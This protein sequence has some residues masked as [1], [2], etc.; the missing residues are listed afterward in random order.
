MT[1]A[2]RVNLY[3]YFVFERNKYSNNVSSFKGGSGG[4]GSRCPLLPCNRFFCGGTAILNQAGLVDTIETQALRLYRCGTSVS[5][6]PS[7]AD[8]LRYQLKED[9]SL[10]SLKLR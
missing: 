3:I 1:I 10:P 9:A 2:S 6:A 7:H 5:V 4:Y 8:T